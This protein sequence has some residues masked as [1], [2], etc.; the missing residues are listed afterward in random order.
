MLE[1]HLQF[2]SGYLGD[3]VLQTICPGWPCVSILPILAS[4]VARIYRHETQGAPGRNIIFLFFFF[5][6]A[7]GLNSG[8]HT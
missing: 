6:V 5:F 8:H 2:I 7:L 1:P 4:P 3:G